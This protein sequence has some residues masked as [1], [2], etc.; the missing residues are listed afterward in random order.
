MGSAAIPVPIANDVGLLAVGVM[1]LLH[2]GVCDSRMWDPQW[3]AVTA[4]HHAVRCDLRGYG[5]SPLPPGPYSHGRDLLALLEQDHAVRNRM[6]LQ[7]VRCGGQIVQQD[8]GALATCEKMLERE[9]LTSIAQRALSQQ[10][11]LGQ[12]IEHDSRGIELG[13]SIEN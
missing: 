11:Q 1:V 3:D 13:D 5:R 6:Q 4:A 10:A 7:V 2:A 8:Y 9:N 12:A